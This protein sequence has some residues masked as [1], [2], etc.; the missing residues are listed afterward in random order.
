MSGIDDDSRTG[1][2]RA[3]A[4]IGYALALGPLTGV[5]ACMAAYGL[6]DRQWLALTYKER[7]C[8][9]NRVREL[10][11][12]L[13]KVGGR[14]LAEDKQRRTMLYFLVDV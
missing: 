4:N 14:I 6:T 11:S 12:K 5:G 1:H 9:R 13:P 8:L 10:L 7:D 3:A 2:I